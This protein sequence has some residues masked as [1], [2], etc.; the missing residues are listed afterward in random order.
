MSIREMTTCRNLDVSI[1]QIVQVIITG[2]YDGCD[3]GPQSEVS[4]CKPQS[5]VAC[6]QSIFKLQYDFI[7]S[8]LIDVAIM[9]ET[10]AVI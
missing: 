7:N 4:N 8:I 6:Y 5:T 9:I 3:F 2:V 1:L 10:V